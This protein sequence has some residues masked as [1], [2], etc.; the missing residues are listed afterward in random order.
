MDPDVIT[1]YYSQSLQG[2]PTTLP[3]DSLNQYVTRLLEVVEIQSYGD[4]E[5]YASQ[6]KALFKILEDKSINQSPFLLDG[7]TE[8][9]LTFVRHCEND[10]SI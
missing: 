9:I 1:S 5:T 10:V 4:G 8:M 3:A 2:L 7:A 6:L